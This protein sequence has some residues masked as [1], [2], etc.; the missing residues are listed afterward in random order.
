[1]VQ[2]EG[3]FR[4]HCHFASFKGQVPEYTGTTSSGAEAGHVCRVLARC[5]FIKLWVSC[6]DSLQIIYYS[7]CHLCPWIE[8]SML[9]PHIIGDGW[10]QP[11]RLW[12]S[13]C[14]V[15]SLSAHFSTLCSL[16]LMTRW[17]SSLMTW[18]G[19]GFPRIIL[20]LWGVKFLKR[21]HFFYSPPSPV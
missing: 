16:A 8:S 1:M 12:H 7:C 3:K 4:E 18:D 5:Q 10:P 2:K 13:E 21:R 6:T 15:I 14:L 20:H 19:L 9:M 11:V 17:H